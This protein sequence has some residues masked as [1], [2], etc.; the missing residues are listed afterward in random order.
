M[1][2][3]RNQR[4]PIRSF[5]CMALGLTLWLPGQARAQAT[6]NADAGLEG[7]YKPR[8]WLPVQLTL[9]NQGAPARV[10]VR[11]RIAHGMEG[12]QEYRLPERVLPSNANERHTLYLKPP[13]TYTS[14][15]L[16]LELFRDGRPLNVIRAPLTVVN[17]GE[18]LVLGL[19]SGEATASLKLL[20][21]LTVPAQTFPSFPGGP[22]SSIRGTQARVNVAVLPPGRTPD[23][24][25]GLQ[26]ADMVILAGISERE[27]S[28][29]QQTALRDYTNAGGTLVVTGGPNWARLTTP[30]FSEI[31][32][33]RVTGSRTASSLF[34]MRAL[35]GQPLSAG[36]AFA[37]C[38]GEPKPGT[39]VKVADGGFPVVATRL[40]GSGRVVFVAFDPSLPPFNTWSGSLGFWKKL[41]VNPPPPQ[42]I[43]SVT[44][45][46]GYDQDMYGNPAAYGRL[47]DAPFT[48]SQLDIPAF[49]VVALF[50]L[51][52]IVVL[53]PLNYYFLK[54]RDKKEYAWLTTPAIVLV[55]SVGAYLIGYGFK[56]G[57][58]LVAKVGLLEAR[59]GQTRAAGLAYFGLFSPRKTTYDIQVAPADGGAQDEGASTLLSEPAG[60][61]SGAAIRVLQGDAQR[62]AGFAVDMWAMRV[63]KAEGMTDLGRGIQSNWSVRNNRVTG[64]IRNDSPFTLEDCRLIVDGQVSPFEPLAPGKQARFDVPAAPGGGTGSLLP[65]ALLSQLQGSSGE[66]RMKR[67]VLEPLCSG[68]GTLQRAGPML[69]GWVREPVLRLHVDGRPPREQAAT[70]MVVH[71]Q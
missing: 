48:I 37:L 62:V 13:Q 3:R 19:G 54:A 2:H 5:L 43:S 35:A 45:A 46:E 28:P 18:W 27:L 24:W 53:V 21:S 29:Q 39:T 8:R 56:G 6:L 44:A 51:A 50:L 20:A 66:Q 64:T 7:Y 9:T 57:R 4:F 16:V 49:Y 36:T 60:N 63:L 22:A 70:L 10:Y 34:S 33:V 40:Q 67:A 69:L 25:Q 32:P 12:D 41:L 15:P 55:F 38:T 23:R 65:Q 31:L 1:I 26:A 71:L 17:E 61:R 59:S 58:T 68:T 47:A 11:T 14:Q 42:L 30:F 52:Y